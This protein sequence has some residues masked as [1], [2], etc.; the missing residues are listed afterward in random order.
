MA[1]RK[2][3]R[4]YRTPNDLW[5]KLEKEWSMKFGQYLWYAYEYGPDNP[6]TL[7]KFPTFAEARQ[8]VRESKITAARE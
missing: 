2:P 3:T 4:I 6:K 5:I 7:G 1:R 8:F